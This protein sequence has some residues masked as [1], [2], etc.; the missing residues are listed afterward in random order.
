M[1]RET[2]RSIWTP[3]PAVNVACLV[4]CVRTSSV[5]DSVALLAPFSARPRPLAVVHALR[6]AQCVTGSVAGKG[7]CVPRT[8]AAA[9]IRSAITA[10]AGRQIDAPPA[11][12][13]RLVT[14]FATTAVVRETGPAAALVVV[15][16]VSAAHPHLA[17]L[18]SFAVA[19]ESAVQTVTH[20][21]LY[22]GH[23]SSAVTIREHSVRG[24][25]A[26]RRLTE[27]RTMSTPGFTAEAALYR[28]RG[29]YQALS[30]RFDAGPGGIIPQ[31]FPMCTENKFCIPPIWYC[32][33]V[34]AREDGTTYEVDEVCGGC[35]F[36]IP[37]TDIG[38]DWPWDW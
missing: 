7:K 35:M 22:P 27:V 8:G 34:C 1:T 15:R 6:G 13:V 11:A 33:H 2:C 17:H 12:A 20:A 14:P 18:V 26:K 28:T 24:L 36:G 37:F 31:D 21:G 9:Q 25:Q 3:A 38:I 16:R 29:N 4:A 32:R 10:V 30:S 5:A 23:L 19:A